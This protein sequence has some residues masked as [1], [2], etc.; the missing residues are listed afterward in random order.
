MPQLVLGPMLRYLD[1]TSATIWVETDAPTTVYVW[2]ENVEPASS[3]TF[4]VAG[5]HYAIVAVRGLTPGSTVPYSVELGDEMVWPVEDGEQSGWPPSVLRPYEPGRPLRLAFGS[6]RAA[7]PLDDPEWGVDALHA[8]AERMRRASPDDW[9]DLVA[10]VGDQVYADDN[11]S[12]ETERYIAAHRG[13]DEGPG[14][15]V[16]NVDEYTYLYAESWSPGPIRWLLSTLPSVMIFD[17]HDVRDDWNTSQPWRRQI[18]A[19]GWWQ[20][21]ITSG[22]L[23]Y[24]LYQHLGNLSPDE[25]DSNE[26]LAALRGADGDGEPLLREFAERADAAA[27]GGRGVHWS[28]ARDYGGVRL[29][30]LDSRCNRVVDGRQR[31]MV[32]DTEW[33]WFEEQ[34][35][36]DV[37]HLLVVTSLPYLLPPG[38]HGLEAFDE[39]L[40]AGQWGPRAARI[41]EKVRQGVDLEHWA[42]FETSFRRMKDAITAVASGRRGEPPATITFL[43][44]DVH[45][46]YLAEAELATDA[47][48]PTRVLQAV[49]SPIRNPLPRKAQVAERL[50]SSNVGR[51]VGAFLANRGHASTP[52]L[53]WTVTH[54]PAFGNTLAEVV[55]SDGSIRVS[56]SGAQDGPALAQSWEAEFTA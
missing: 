8:L 10:F 4:C 3:Q 41:A 19:T 9:P 49:C 55:L 5:H 40:A 14:H 30:V 45:F 33:Q 51:A 52:G 12:P 43:S 26:L 47:P 22:L 17:D 53:A 37:R 11:L 20:E 18:Q 29:I 6:C 44:G 23:T 28:Y 31:L 13:P 36:G 1:S 24:W 56:V 48:S 27:D 25:L 16:S 50:A 39:A 42:A 15:E 32:G 54:G 7:A 2:A 21:R 38:V 46:S 35:R 34:C